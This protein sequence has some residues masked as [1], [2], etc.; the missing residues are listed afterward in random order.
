MSLRTDDV[1]SRSGTFFSL[2]YLA[3]AVSYATTSF[4]RRGDEPTTIN[5]DKSSKT[6][7]YKKEV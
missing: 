7:T 3:L 4:A 5:W 1:A 2:L 6:E